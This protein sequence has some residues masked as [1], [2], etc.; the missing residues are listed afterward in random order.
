MSIVLKR[1]KLVL[2]GGVTVHKKKSFIFKP[3]M[4]IVGFCLI[5]A[6]CNVVERPTEGYKLPIAKFEALDSI[7][8][9]V[10]LEFFREDGI[11][12]ENNYA[13]IVIHQFAKSPISFSDDALIPFQI[14]GTNIKGEVQLDIL[15]TIN[16]PE[17]NSDEM[18]SL[19]EN[20]ETI[21]VILENYE[22]VNLVYRTPQI[23][24]Q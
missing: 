6:S 2:Q 13:T 3:L 19:I 9:S 14:K 21:T 4:L 20:K 5:L 10:G 7:H 8:F 12:T 23:P 24:S 16:I 18:K 1:D 11:E 22:E 15:T 17:I